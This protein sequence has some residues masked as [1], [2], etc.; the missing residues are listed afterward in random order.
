MNIFNNRELATVTLI[1]AVFVW[2]FIKNRDF[3]T[4]IKLALKSLCQKPILITTGILLLYISIVVHLLGRIDVWNMGQLKNTILWFVFVGFVQFINTAKITDL[5]E[6][7]KTSLNSQVRL[8]VLIEFLVV[9]DSYGFVMEL[10]L[11]TT[12]TFLLCCSA[13]AQYKP[14]FQQQKKVCD[15]LLAVIG[16]LVLIHSILNIYTEPSKFVSID[17]FR[18]FLV[19]ILLSISLLPCVYIFYYVLAYDRAFIKTHI[20]TNS[21][22]LRRYAKIRSFFAFKGK[23]SLINKWLLYSCTR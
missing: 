21:K 23:P 3:L 5:K 11:V 13:L 6:Y 8:V 17:T 14:E 15:Y 9:F 1:M 20:Y 7:L 19:P 10:F 2:T 22:Q 16:T 18:D 12:V 4:T